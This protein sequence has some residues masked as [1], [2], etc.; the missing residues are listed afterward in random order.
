M[1]NIGSKKPCYSF[2]F[3]AFCLRFRCNVLSCPLPSASFSCWFCLLFLAF[4]FLALSCAGQPPPDRLI[5]S[6]YRGGWLPP[7]F[8]PWFL[9]AFSLQ[10]SYLSLAFWFLFLLVLLAFP[11]VSFSCA[12]L[13]GATPPGQTYFKSV[14]G[15]LDPALLF[16]LL[17]ACVFVAIFF[18]APCLPAGF[19]CFSLR[20]LSLRVLARAP[21]R[22]DLFEVCPGGVGSRPSFYL[23]FC[24][25]FRCN[26]ISCPLAVCFLFPLVLL[27]LAFPFLALS[28]AGQPPRDRLILSLSR[29]GWLPPFF[30]PCF[31]LAFS[32][33]SSSV[34]GFLICFGNRPNSR[35]SAN[36]RVS[37]A[38]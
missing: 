36:K 23:A 27:F 2:R 20:F 24:L 16:T 34:V 35:T 30:L 14:P 10:F 9:L 17:F 5:L 15:G 38:G 31:L 11:C 29:G 32:W 1:Y 6:L 28:C 7:F 3:L 25:R 8:I 22:T 12:F 21:P 37:A 33:R 13:R 4:P 18:L 19:A 26:F